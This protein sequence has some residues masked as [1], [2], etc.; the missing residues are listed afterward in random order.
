[1]QQHAETPLTWIRYTIAALQWPVTV[2]AAFALGRYVKGLETRLM[3]S[4]RNL[5]DL[6]ER[7]L[8]YVHRAL[9]EVKGKLDTISALLTKGK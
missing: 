2:F 9:A 7:H 5:K 4:E 6:I 3:A 8:P 1:M